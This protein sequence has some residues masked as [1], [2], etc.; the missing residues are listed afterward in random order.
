MGYFGENLSGFLQQSLFHGMLRL[1]RV[2]PAGEMY[3]QLAHG[4]GVQQC[5]HKL[6]DALGV[7]RLTV[8]HDGLQTEGALQIRLHFPRRLPRRVAGVD[9]HKEWLSR[10]LH[11]G[12]GPFFRLYVILPGNFRNGAVGGHHNADGAMPLH[13]LFRP[14]LRRFRHGNLVVVPWGGH[15]PGHA[16]LLRAHRAVHHVAHGVDQTNFGSEVMMVFPEPLWGS[17]SLARSLR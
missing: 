7:Q 12:D 4:E 15:H 10:F 3:P 11:V 16:V 8:R 1:Q 17:S 14:Q 6:P 2:H 9:D 13:D 5:L